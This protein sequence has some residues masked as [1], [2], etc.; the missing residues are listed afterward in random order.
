MSIFLPFCILHFGFQLS[1]FLVHV[2][3]TLDPIVNFLYYSA[4]CILDSNCQF[5][6]HSAFCI[7]DSNLPSFKLHPRTVANHYE[8]SVLTMP[9]PPPPTNHSHLHY[10]ARPALSLHETS[11]V[12]QTLMRGDPLLSAKV[13]QPVGP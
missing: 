9:R 7:L 2:F 13:D 3:C 5:S 12:G 4:F 11:V 1:I 8:Y 10:S 6:Y